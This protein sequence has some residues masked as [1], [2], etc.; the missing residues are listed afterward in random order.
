M[1]VYLGPRSRDRLVGVNPDLVR[2]IELAAEKSPVDFI[3]HEG[4]RFKRTSRN[5]YC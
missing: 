1:A 3:V 5:C 4:F 2:V